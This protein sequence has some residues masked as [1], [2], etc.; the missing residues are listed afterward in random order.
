MSLGCVTPLSTD[1][2]HVEAG[3][4][5]PPGEKRSPGRPR[6]QPGGWPHH[7]HQ[8][9]AQGSRPVQPSL[10]LQ[11]QSPA[12]ERAITPSTRQVI[13]LPPPPGGSCGCTQSSH[14]AVCRGCGRP[15]AGQAEQLWDRG[16]FRSTLKVWTR[17][18]PLAHHAV[19]QGLSRFCRCRSGGRI[20]QA[21]AARSSDADLKRQ[22]LGSQGAAAASRIGWSWSTVSQ[23]RAIS[24]FLLSPKTLTHLL[25]QFHRRQPPASR[26][27]AAARSEQRMTHSV[28]FPAWQQISRRPTRHRE[29]VGNPHGNGHSDRT[30]DALA[31]GALE[32]APMPTFQASAGLVAVQEDPTEP[33]GDP[34]RQQQP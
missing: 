2:R 20:T 29:A 33:I 19:R 12:I 30:L 4:I 15:G 17:L 8:Q 14:R 22:Q 34:G 3:E 24:I 7:Q 28:F 26:R 18:A 21:I 25:G 13:G 16:Y 5:G 1:P 23:K 9:A 31:I 10:T 27:M 6:S 32:S 11:G